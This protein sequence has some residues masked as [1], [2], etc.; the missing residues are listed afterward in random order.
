MPQDVDKLKTMMGEKPITEISNLNMSKIQDKLNRTKSEVEE[1]ASIIQEN[2]T[3]VHKR[4]KVDEEEESS[5]GP[6]NP[7]DMSGT[8]STQRKKKIIEA[9]LSKLPGMKGTKA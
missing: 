7:S 5:S 9:C 2:S 8:F 3:K 6:S 1:Q 4:T